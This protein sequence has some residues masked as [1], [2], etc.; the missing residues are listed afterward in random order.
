MCHC[1]GG[2]LPRAVPS[3]TLTASSSK[4]N[5]SLC[6]LC[7]TDFFGV[8]LQILY[9]AEVERLWL[10]SPKI[11]RIID[12]CRIAWQFRYTR[13]LPFYELALVLKRLDDVA[14]L[15]VNANYGIV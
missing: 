14:C 7:P 11:V 5:A 4:M 6:R 12:T 15:I 8:V 2:A 13:R 1:Q 10:K 3:I 9:R